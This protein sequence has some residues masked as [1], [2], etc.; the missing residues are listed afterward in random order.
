MPLPVEP[1]CLH[2]SL[3]HLGEGLLS[4]SGLCSPTVA[5]VVLPVLSFSWLP[6][7]RPYTNMATTPTSPLYSAKP[8]SL[9]LLLATPFLWLCGLIRYTDKVRTSSWAPGAQLL[10]ATCPCCL[11]LVGYLCPHLPVAT[12]SRLHLISA[13]SSAFV[14]PLSAQQCLGSHSPLWYPLIICLHL[15]LPAPRAVC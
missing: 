8:P 9:R 14:S 7:Y 10:T 3:K 12:S 4:L 11:P 2:F 1:A 6:P 13:S 15:P 5:P